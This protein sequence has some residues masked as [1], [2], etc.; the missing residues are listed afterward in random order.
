MRPPFILVTITACVIATP[1]LGFELTD[2]IGIAAE[3]VG[4][5]LVPDIGPNRTFRLWAVTPDDWRIESVAG[6]SEVGM[7]FEVVGGTFYQHELGGPTS[8]GINPALFVLSPDLEWDSYLTVGSLTSVDNNLLSVGIVWDD[9]EGGG[10]LLQSDNGA[11]TATIGNPQGDATSFTDACGRARQGVL[12]AQF[13]LVGEA[14]SLEGSVL[15]QGRDELDVVLQAHIT[16]F[17]ID[18][19]AVSDTYPEIVCSADVSGDGQVTT[20]DLYVVMDGWNDSV[21]GGIN[22]DFASGIESLLHVLASWGECP[23]E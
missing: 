10:N 1:S 12:I 19:D 22:D 16:E 14:A 13:T 2:K 17:A 21:C 23:P 20:A 3:V 4:T 15:L 6:N 5:N 18:S 8:L 11:I 7:R 9:F